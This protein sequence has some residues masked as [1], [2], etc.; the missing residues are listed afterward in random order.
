MKRPSILAAV[1]LSLGIGW[2]VTT[3]AFDH[4]YQQH[5]EQNGMPQENDCD[6]ALAQG[7]FDLIQQFIDIDA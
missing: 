7:H 6:T 5:Y 3:S 2:A 4:G 1:G